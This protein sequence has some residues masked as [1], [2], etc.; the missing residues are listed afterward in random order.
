MNCL[1][2]SVAALVLDSDIESK[3]AIYMHLPPKVL[4]ASFK[5]ETAP[6][7]RKMRSQLVAKF[8]P[9]FRLMARSIMFC[10]KKYRILT[11]RNKK[12]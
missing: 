6:E 10:N 8:I 12:Y 5:S 9:F 1:Q 11:F 2:H 4:K 7:R 3:L